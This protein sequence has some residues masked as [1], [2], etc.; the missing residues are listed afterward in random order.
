MAFVKYR[1]KTKYNLKGKS[2]QIPKTNTDHGNPQAHPEKLGDVDAE[3]TLYNEKLRKQLEK[4]DLY[5]SFTKAAK[6]LRYTLNSGGLVFDDTKEQSF[7]KE[8]IYR[9]MEE[10]LAYIVNLQQGIFFAATHHIRALLELYASTEYVLSEAGRKNRF[11]ERFHQFPN[12]TFYK[13]F[14]QHDNA[15]LKLSEE[16]C[17]QF[18]SEFDELKPEIFEAFGKKKPEELL[19]LPTW[20]GN[21]KIATLFEACSKPEIIK[22]DYTK[23]CLFTHLSSIC[24][25]SNSEVFPTFCK[26]QEALLITTVRYSAFCYVCIKQNDLL[27]AAVQDK[28]DDIFLPLAEPLTKAHA[29]KGFVIP[30]TSD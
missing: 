14:H 4:S 17:K 26:I 16:I 11:L 27:N 23:L 7:A 8:I 15:F 2:L 18:F 13:V 12:L 3:E 29:D 24:R 28:L 19:Q 10:A 6:K 21:A 1:Y 25:R 9:I 20:L 30:S 22:S 5:V